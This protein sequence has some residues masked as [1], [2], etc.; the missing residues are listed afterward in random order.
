MAGVSPWYTR[1]LEKYTALVYITLATLVAIRDLRG[2]EWELM[3]MEKAKKRRSLQRSTKRH[4][5]EELM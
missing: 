4:I 5:C 1:L 2:R 3:T